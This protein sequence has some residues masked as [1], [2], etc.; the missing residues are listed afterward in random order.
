MSRW[1][2]KAD[3]FYKN[4]PGR[5]LLLMLQKSGAFR[6]SSR[7]LRTRLS[8]PL[9]ARYIRRNNIDMQPFEGQEFKNFASFFARK[10]DEHEVV[11][12]AEVLISPCDGWLSIHR[13]TEDVTLSIKGSHYRLDDLI[14]EREAAARFSSGMCFILRLE[15]SDYHHFCCFDDLRIEE[16]HYVK[17]KLHSVQP[18]ALSSVPVYRLNRRWWSLLETRHFGKAVQIEVGAMLVGGVTLAAERTWLERG[19]EM[20]NFELAGSTIVL[21][22][23]QSVSSRICL[24]SEFL[25]AREGAAEVKVSMGEGIGRLRE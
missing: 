18:V 13:I 9:I 23:D 3:I 14:T 25:D 8:R 21:I 17:G 7:F 19:D 11:P 2:A 24:F 15:A 16:S 1:T 22:L 4:I 12:D 5:L 6:A 20:G 10:L